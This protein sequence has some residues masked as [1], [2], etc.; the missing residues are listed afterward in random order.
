MSRTRIVPTVSLLIAFFV[1]GSL[2]FLAV[3]RVKQRTEQFTQITIRK[4]T[5]AGQIN[6][7]Q[8]EGYARTLL[9]LGAD[10]SEDRS[11]LRAAIEDFREKTG[12]V[13]SQYEAQLTTDESRRRYQ[14]LTEKRNQYQKIRNQ[15]I[16]LNDQDKK[17]ESVQLARTLLWPAYQQ[18]TLAGDV[19]FDYDISA[20][21]ASANDV[22][23]LCTITQFMAAFISI[24]GFFGGI[25]VPFVLMWLSHGLKDESLHS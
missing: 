10:S 23:K 6:S 16:A 5:W 11:S 8:A 2:S 20:A 9:L 17:N 22:L 3:G 21:A 15:I 1:F 19:L 18:Y 14:D 12:A 24:V 25:A 7:Y 13:L 4:L